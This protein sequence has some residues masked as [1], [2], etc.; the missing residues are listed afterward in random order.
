MCAGVLASL[1]GVASAEAPRS[2]ATLHGAASGAATVTL[3]RDVPGALA[4]SRDQG[5]LNPATTLPHVRLA[6]TRPADRQAALDRLAHDQVTRGTPSYHR[7]LSPAQLRAY[8]PAPADIAKVTGWLISRGL[9]VNR[10]SPSGMS[11]DFSGTAGTVGAAFNTR[12]H[13]VLRNGEAHVSNVTAPAI[14]AELA[15]LVT[16]V[17]LSNFFPKPAMRR[18]TPGFTTKLGNSTYYAVA[19][20]DFATIYNVNPLRG[21]NN[22]YGGPITGAGV[23]LAMV[24]QTAIQS[25]DWNTFRTTFGLSGYKGTLTQINPGGCTAPGTTGDEG[26]AALDTEWS[27]AVAPDAAILEASCAGAAPFEFGV[28][29]ALENLVEGGTPATIFSISYEDPE[30]EGGYS[31]IAAWTNLLEEGAVQGKSIFVAAGDNG[32]STDRGEIDSAGLFVNGLADSAYNV[33]VGGTDFYDSALGE[34]ATYWKQGN[35]PYGESAISYIPEI[36]W[37]NSCANSII[38]KFNKGGGAIPFCNANFSGPLQ[39]G[40]GGSGSQSVFH[41]KPDW[42]LKTL[43]GMPND[44][45]RDQPDVSLFAANGIWGHFYLFCMSDPNE[46]GAPCNYK[47]KKDL[48]GNAAGGTSFG[49]PAFAGITALIEQTFGGTAL[50]NPAPEFYKVAQAQYATPLGLSQCNSTLG[51]GVSYACAFY[52]VTAGDNNEPCNKGTTDC[53][54]GPKSTQGIGVLGNPISGQGPYAYPAQPGYDLATGLGTVNV[55]NLLYNYY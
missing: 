44:G 37:D 29:T 21:N 54:V 2:S 16:G 28:Y 20:A 32:T 31:F 7:W 50:G 42:Q 39:N 25:A 53:V 11:V 52:D 46:G 24:E 5:E 23:T 36:P 47:I 48:L 13:N 51:N 9:H 26:E 18:Y 19:P 4:T 55:T 12:L 1:S 8:G 45:V 10:V 14:P 34:D 30:S 17:T 43:L 38:W 27:S 35:G 3:P 49:S 6:L 33:S 15:P 40:I 41:T 22:A